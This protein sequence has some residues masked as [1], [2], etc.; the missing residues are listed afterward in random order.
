MLEE[1]WPDYAINSA[2]IATK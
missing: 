2:I 1:T